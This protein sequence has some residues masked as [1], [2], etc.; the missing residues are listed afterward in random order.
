MPDDDKERSNLEDLFAHY[1]DRLN[2]G[3]RIG[4]EEILAD[5][6]VHG[7]EIL[8][9]LEEF[10]ER[11]VDG[12]PDTSLG[13]L[14]DYTLHRQIGRGGMGVVYEAWENS[15]DRRVALK[16]LPPGVAADERALQRFIREAKT[17][18]QLR[19]PN[20][21]GVY[22]TGVKEGTP[23]YA[24]EF[25]EG[26]TLAQLLPQL[27]GAE[28]E[29]ATVF[30]RKDCAGYFEKIADAFADVAD[31]LQHA[32]S[33]R[34]IH[35][36]IKPSNLMRD[37][38]GRL[39]ILDFGLARLEGQESLTLSGDLVGTP[40]Y[41]SPEQARRR[42]IEIDH[43]TDIYSLGATLYEL[44]CG[45]PPFRGK[46]HADTLSQIMEHDPVD[47]KKLN[48][49]VPKDLETIVLKCLRKHPADRYSTAE[50]LSQDLRRSA[51]GDLIEARPQPIG[52]KVARWALIHRARLATGAVVGILLAVSGILLYR[53]GEEARRRRLAAYDDRV[54]AA[55]VTMRT[56]GALAPMAKEFAWGALRYDLSLLGEDASLLERQ[57]DRLHGALAALEAARDSVPEKSDALYYLAMGTLLAGDEERA[58]KELAILVRRDYVPAMALQ[59]VILK[60]RGKHSMAEELLARAAG[61]RGGEWAA[62]WCA[63]Y[64]AASDARWQD[65]AAAYEKLIEMQRGRREPYYLG[66]SVDLHLN[67]GLALLELHEFERARDHFVAAGA[68]CST[69]V[70]PELFLG[71]TLC[72]QGKD[73]EGERLLDRLFQ[74]VRSDDVA[75]L[76]A[77]FYGARL[78]RSEKALA[79]VDRMSPGTLKDIWKC[80]CL[81][82]L[83]RV[84]EALGIARGLAASTP[85]SA[86]CQLA[87]AEV[88]LQAGSASAAREAASRALTLAPRSGMPHT[89]L[90]LAHLEMGEISRGHEVAR[91][92]VELEPDVPDTHFLLG[93]IAARMGRHDEAAESFR[94]TIRLGGGS[95]RT[96]EAHVALGQVLGAL[97]KPREAL[98]ACIEAIA[99]RRASKVDVPV[100]GEMLLL[101][102]RG[103]KSDFGPELDRAIRV[104]ERELADREQKGGASDTP[105]TEAIRAALG[106][107][108]LR[109][110]EE[111][112]PANRER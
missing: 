66:S 55:A 7:P 47:P 8:E 108:R 37:Q 2:G 9:H 107:G 94:R 18:G 46:D 87:L 26:E 34:V 90:A 69:A 81:K 100:E 96:V 39:R 70:E 97:G 109:A 5:N 71:F 28:P 12:E 41:M 93:R 29:A 31:G 76:A 45:R 60:R 105:A 58:L 33:K 89:V 6:P 21:V 35:R 62:P 40:V 17:A 51:R 68:L 63:A 54:I 101:L 20:V 75:E 56:S 59:A 11:T 50:A 104:L 32:H 57:H 72:Y 99:L 102:S 4:R 36:D 103:T 77:I 92:G 78:R 44:L 98:A 67:G 73:E 80:V 16:V 111:P 95:A 10:I 23:W 65:A 86:V 49:R 1:I 22:S 14:G 38:E 53:S 106:E 112:G 24:M 88:C 3:E 79:W 83:D 91:V 48:P 13:T 110:A 64:G 74:R 15:M 82:N 85:D 19:H 30:G 27:K 43:R 84:P 42:K 25:V 61:S 52:E